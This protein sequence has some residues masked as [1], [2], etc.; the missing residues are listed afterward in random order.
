MELEALSAPD[1]PQSL[2]ILIAEDSLTQ[3]MKLQFILEEQG[4]HV[5]AARN[6]AI[7]LKMLQ[8][9]V[10]NALPTLVITD[11]EMPEL[12]GYELCRA[13]KSDERLKHLPVM[14]LTSLSDPEDVVKGLECGADSF[15]VKPYE[16]EFL[17]ARLQ[18]ILANQQLRAQN[19]PNSANGLEVFFAGQKHTLEQAPSIQTTLDLLLGTYE[20]AIQ[21]KAELSQ[22]K[23]SLEEQ[24]R[25]LANSNTE[26]EQIGTEL[27]EKNERMQADLD[28]AREIQ[29]AFILKQYPS[30]PH[31]FAPD[32]SA[33]R[34]LHRWIPTT[35]L[36][37]DFFDV[38]ALSETKA[39]VFIC[40]VMGHGVRSALVTAMMRAL[41]GERTSVAVD[42]GQFLG[43]INRHL[44]AILQQTRTPMFASAFYMVADV[45]TG[46]LT[47]AN[48]GHPSPILVRR[49][50][51]DNRSSVEWLLEASPLSGPALGVFEDALYLTEERE[52]QASDLM[53][54]FTDG[55]FEVEG[56]DEE[57]GEERLLDG[58]R[59]RVHLAPSALFDDLLNEIRE[60][61]ATGDFED[62]VCLVGV[63]VTRL[64]ISNSP[65]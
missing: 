38:L 26:L 2:E 21:K 46:R 8:E 27:R 44:L 6:G 10:G 65:F 23:A 53:M 7:A 55:L 39:G 35:T 40:D 48:A 60:Y 63:E 56:A 52:L 58:V 51:G 45:E 25:K 3:A 18:Y 59:Q 19:L 61:G 43:E 32:Q 1:S 17:L 47:Y 36:G 5:A 4:Y 37:G 54:L 30:F 29:N 14:L 57:F 16:P 62:D 28:L 31:H 49:G 64:G 33:L 13:I 20:T 12:T 22:A 15:V 24:A 9:R 50:Q 34:F 41:V 42:P 11:I